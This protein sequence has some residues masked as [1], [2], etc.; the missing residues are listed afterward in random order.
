MHPGSRCVC[1]RL[2]PAVGTRFEPEKKRLLLE[3][4]IRTVV[5]LLQQQTC[6]KGSINYGLLR[7]A[8]RSPLSQYLE[9]TRV[10]GIY[11]LCAVLLD[12]LHY[13]PTSMKWSARPSAT[14]T[15]VIC[16]CPAL[17]L[18]ALNPTF[19]SYPLRVTH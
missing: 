17:F 11:S 5:G 16:Q 19:V 13:L 9:S 14:S 3:R 8:V 18:T 6:A 10:K 1:T 2:L 15:M 12:S 7:S 4:L